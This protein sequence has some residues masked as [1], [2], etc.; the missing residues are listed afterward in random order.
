[1]TEASGEHLWVETADGWRLGLLHLP[2]AG[3][4][5]G[6]ILA[7]HA[8]MVDRRSL[9][10]PEG[11]GMLSYLASQGWE[12][13][14]PDLRG[15]GSSGPTAPE[16]GRWSYDDLVRY[17]LPACLAVVRA[18][19][20]GLPV[21]VLGHSLSGHVSVAAAGAGYYAQQPEAHVLLS[22]NMW[23]P[24]LEDSAGMRLLKCGA[25]LA[26][27]LLARLFGG[28][29]ARLLRV[30]PVDESG[31]YISDL[32]RFWR[33][34]R[35]GADDGSVDYLASMADVEGPVLALIGRGDRLLA[36]PA[37]ARRWSEL[38]GADGADFRVLGRGDLGLSFDPDHM[39]L[40]TDP[41][42]RPIWEEIHRWL[43]DRVAAR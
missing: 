20:K 21:A 12:V 30:G 37:G 38:I 22:A 39:A 28:F 2:A 43:C 14:A 13:Y 19:S 16:G 41:R 5:R 42:S 17:D 10:R 40:V 27:D 36:H 29:P 18:R 33:E 26:L 23:A 31:S 7:G 35:W 32:V 8:M 11:G 6:A 34:D 9:D 24:S 4:V 3:S 1:M 25:C 15:R